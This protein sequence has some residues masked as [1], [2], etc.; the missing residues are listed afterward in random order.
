M[1][2]KKPVNDVLAKGW[3]GLRI[4]TEDRD[5]YKNSVS[6]LE[7][8]KNRLAQEEKVLIGPGNGKRNKNLV[9]VTCKRWTV[10]RV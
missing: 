7:I 4:G 9:S 6:P 1:F 3:D 8:L 2:E 5:V 10:G